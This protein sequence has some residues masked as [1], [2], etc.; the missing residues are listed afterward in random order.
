MPVIRT[1]KEVYTFI[2]KRS[3]ETGEPVTVLIDR[4]FAEALKNAKD[5][6]GTKSGNKSRDS[7]GYLGIAGLVEK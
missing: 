6:R 3:F 7:E 2:M 1:S 4:I 5:N